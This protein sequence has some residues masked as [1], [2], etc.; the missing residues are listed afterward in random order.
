VHDLADILVV[1]LRLARRA[2]AL[3]SQ[4]GTDQCAAARTGGR[5]ATG[6]E[7]VKTDSGLSQYFEE[8]ASWDADRRAEAARNARNAWYAAAA[9]WLCAAASGVS[10]ALLLPLKR[11]E[12]FLV[13]VDRSTGIVDVVPAYAGHASLDE[14]VTR[15][16]L[17][18]YITVCERFNFATAQSD[19]EECA[20]FHSPR[21]N[22]AWYALWRTSNPASPLNVH[23]DG[24]SV[25]VKVESVSFFP[26]ENGVSDLAQVR[27]L[28]A[29][30][31]GQGGDERFTHFVATIQ[32]VY[33]RPASDP[34]MRSW[35]PLGF[36]ILELTSE[37]EALVVPS[38]SPG[39]DAK[40][41]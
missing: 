36:K 11:V 30:R 3:R 10:L 4:A 6:V 24:S 5:R 17:V 13:R 23:K 26:R 18:H 20:A 25:R 2:R 29:L 38:T 15:Y 21:R 31:Q 39:V 14:A 34:K 12:P 8:S 7:A 40:D 1:C 32:Y 16:F 35:N 41:K 28:K 9:G 22:Q 37:P 27:Y 19:Y 33:E